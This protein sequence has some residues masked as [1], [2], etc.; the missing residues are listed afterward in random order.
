MHAVLG[1]LPLSQCSVLVL[2]TG[3]RAVSTLADGSVLFLVTQTTLR[4]LGEQSASDRRYVRLLNSALASPELL[5][6]STGDA[7]RSAQSCSSLPPA[8]RWDGVDKRFAWNAHLAAPLLAAGGGGFVPP[9][10]CG[11]AGETTVGSLTAAL[12]CRR[13]CGRMGRRLWTR[14]CDSDAGHAANCVELETVLRGSSGLAS[15]LQLRGSV[16]LSW[17][18]SPCLLPKPPLSLGPAARSAAACRAHIASLS[19]SYGSPLLLLSLL[20]KG[21]HR[22]APLGEAY[23]ATIAELAAQE[24]SSLRFEA[25]DWNGRSSTTQPEA[26]RA[27]L[28]ATL[29]PHL[30]REQGLFCVRGSDGAVRSSQSGIIRSNCLDSCDRTNIAQALIG[31]AVLGRMCLAA[32]GEATP[33]LREA[34]QA[35]WRDGG[36]AISLHYA[37]TAAQ[38]RRGA[39][40]G[41]GRLARLC[42]TLRDVQISIMRYAVNNHADGER[43]DADA[44]VSG[45]HVPPREAAAPFPTGFGRVLAALRSLPLL[46]AAAVVSALACLLS[47]DPA[48]LLLSAGC[49][50]LGRRHGGAFVSRPFLRDIKQ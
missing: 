4:F 9:V 12:L 3:R 18:E 11:W 38:R 29:Q 45:T 2:V 48:P 20:R 37:G 19:S 27:A 47:G 26:A 5:Y 23:A 49:L 10:V 31:D 30:A 1:L 39:A 43:S 6:S 33:E 32:G 40:A 41:L 28:L 7:T 25:F 17:T 42:L 8:L 13:H 34:L 14:G 36:D 46:Q 35:L 22:E 15:F 44:L 24:D 50:Q 21:K 16:P